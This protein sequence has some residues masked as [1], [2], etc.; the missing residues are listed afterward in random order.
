MNC[1]RQ[2]AEIREINSRTFK[3]IAEGIGRLWPILILISVAVTARVTPY[4][5]FF[6]STLQSAP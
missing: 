1:D 5:D 2:R 6:V 3:Q 4:W